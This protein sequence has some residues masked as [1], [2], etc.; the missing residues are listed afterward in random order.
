MVASYYTEEDKIE[1]VKTLSI[2][3]KFALASSIEILS[4][5]VYINLTNNFTVLF[6]GL[7]SLNYTS[8]EF[9][10]KLAYFFPFYVLLAYT[11]SSD[12][13]TY[14][15]PEPS[16]LRK[17]VFIPFLISTIFLVLLTLYLFI[18]IRA[19][20]TFKEV[21]Q[22]LYDTKKVDNNDHNFFQNKLLSLFWLFRSSFLIWAVSIGPPFKKSVTTNIPG[23]VYSLFLI[24]YNSAKF[25]GNYIDLYWYQYYLV[26]VVKWPNMQ[27]STAI[28]YLCLFII[29]GLFTIVVYQVAIQYFLVKNMIRKQKAIK[30][31]DQK[32][33]IYKDANKGEIT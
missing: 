15:Y 33:I 22:I 23:V 18:T 17:S 25:L 20:I 4:Y 19:D 16:F 13:M 11:G 30:R 7:F 1:K 8:Y 5:S 9:I 14:H 21:A 2:E 3:G 6:M 29:S 27:M 28:K 31:Q 26:R 24:M 32:E 12:K 10:G